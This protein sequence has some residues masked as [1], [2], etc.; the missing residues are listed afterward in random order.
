MQPASRPTSTRPG[1]PRLVGVDVQ[2]HL[3]AVARRAAIDV[4]RQGGLREQCERVSPTLSWRQVLGHR[5]A[6]RCVGG[7]A[8]QAV[9]RGLEGSLYHRA[10]F[11]GEP[12]AN[13]DHA[14]VVHPRGEL[15]IQV[16]RLCVFGGH[17]AIHAAPR[18]N[19]AFHVRGCAGQ[20]QVQERVRFP[21]WPR[22]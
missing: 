12:P 22:A 3:I 2:H 13:H 19:E 4:G 20:G 8:E 18:A 16:L 5:V 7:I 10:H 1:C 11:R 21:A 6:G 9:R 15:T 17:H 14:V